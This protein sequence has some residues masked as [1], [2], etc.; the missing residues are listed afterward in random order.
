MATKFNALD[1]LL[2]EDPETTPVSEY[3]DREDYLDAMQRQTMRDISERGQA[4]SFVPESLSPQRKLGGFSQIRAGTGPLPKLSNP[5]EDD[6]GYLPA[7]AETVPDLRAPDLRSA[8]AAQQIKESAFGDL[9]LTQPAIQPVPTVQ[10]PVQKTEGTPSAAVAKM[11]EGAGGDESD[12]GRM[13]SAANWIRA[14]ESTGSAISGKNLRSG[15]ADALGEQARQVEA[16]RLKRM[17]KADELAREDAQSAALVSQYKSLAKQGLVPEIPD[18]DTMPIKSAASLIKTYSGLPGTVAKTTKTQ[19]ETEFVGERAET[20]R[21]ERPG[22]IGLVEN[23]VR[24]EAER[25]QLLKEQTALTAAK[26]ED[27]QAKREHDALVREVGSTKGPLFDPKLEQKRKDAFRKDTTAAG[28]LYTE[29]TQQLASLERVSGD[30]LAGKTPSWWD[31]INIQRLKSGV[32]DGLPPDMMAFAK[33]YNAVINPLRHGLFGSALTDGEQKAFADQIEIALLKGPQDLGVSL[34]ELMLAQ[35]DK[36][37][38]RLGY[39]FDEMPDL[40]QNWM[41]TSGFADAIKG[42]SF[43]DMF[44]TPKAGVTIMRGPD[45]KLYRMPND[46][47]AD[48]EKDGFKKE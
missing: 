29:P 14:M 4:Q 5:A 47:V 10:T 9:K 39:L 37:K 20:A 36:T 35:K 13:L 30:L 46:K 44:P 6:E 23:K 11:T 48:A 17:E 1:Q 40:A 28:K 33:R 2:L 19:A 8:P 18:L 12:V 38:L 7:F 31:P 42:T 24:S 45:N 41:Q 15:I 3:P 43:E 34:N 32:T 21:Q 16:L 25:T 26:A 22:K 27:L